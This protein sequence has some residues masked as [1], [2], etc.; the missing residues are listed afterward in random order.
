MADHLKHKNSKAVPIATVTSI[1][2]A[3]FTPCYLRYSSPFALLEVKMSIFK[4][5][6]MGK[7]CFTKRA[8]ALW[9]WFSFFLVMSD[10]ILN[11][12]AFRL[13]H[14][15]LLINARA[16]S[17]DIFGIMFNRGSFST[18]RSIMVLFYQLGSNILSSTQRIFLDDWPKKISLI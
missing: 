6:Y 2:L 16:A 15:W 1:L 14:N 8:P 9:D 4:L 13:R 18:A 3:I 7:S 17:V 5:L 10:I 12:F 11:S